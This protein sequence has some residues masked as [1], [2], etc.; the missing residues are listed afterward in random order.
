M[1]IERSDSDGHEP[2]QVSDYLLPFVGRDFGGGGP[3]SS[4]DLRRRWSSDG[5][6]VR[7]SYD[8]SMVLAAPRHASI[9]GEPVAILDGF[10]GAIC[11][12]RLRSIDRPSRLSTLLALAHTDRQ[13]V[14][15]GSRNGIHL[16]S[17]LSDGCLARQY[18]SGACKGV[19]QVLRE[20]LGV[21][22]AATFVK[23]LLHAPAS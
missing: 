17:S 1:G 23:F 9:E 18:C 2:D 11:L 21:T 7:R 14:G 12:G 3:F 4:G 6:S 16:V 20:R 5:N 13:I 19:V 8:L 22:A 10:M 15:N